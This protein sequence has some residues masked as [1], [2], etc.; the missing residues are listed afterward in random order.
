MTQLTESQVKEMLYQ[1]DQTYRELKDQ[2]A[3]YDNELQLLMKKGKLTAEDELQIATIKKQKLMLKDQMY[4]MIRE[5][6]N[7]LEA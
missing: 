5:R 7:G 2:H 1:N 3:T 4:A 6:I